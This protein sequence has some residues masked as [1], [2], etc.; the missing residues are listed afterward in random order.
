MKNRIVIIG[1]SGI[2]SSNL[3]KKFTKSNYKFI[4]LGR[5]K[6][7]LKKKDSFKLLSK[8]VKKKDIIIFISAEAPAKNIQMFLNNIMICDN[9]CKALQN[10]P[11]SKLIYIS[12]D[13]VYS[14]ISGK[15]NEKT[16]TF[17]GSMHGMMHLTR[18]IQLKMN[19]DNKI[20][21]LRPTL[22]Y[23]PGDTHLGY[24][25]NKFLKLA[26]KNQDIILFGKGEE[27]RDHVFIDDLI[28]IIIECIKKNKIGLFNIASGKVYS[29]RSIAKKIILLTKSKSKILN[30]K[31]IGKMPHNGYRPFNVN[32]INKNFKKVKLTNIED[33]IIKYLRN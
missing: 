16:K 12:S 21:I 24:G 2:I 32:W 5:N 26:K 10:K 22:I 6:I 18:E 30:T 1:S 7:N 28:E 8:K 29:F 13:A 15:I 19:F 17:P 3:Q 20:C 33:G 4:T 25:P 14:D 23:G 9:I 27:K 31:R 11:F